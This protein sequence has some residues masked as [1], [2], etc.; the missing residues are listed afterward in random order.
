MK[1]AAYFR[2][3]PL[4]LA[5]L[6]SAFSAP[7]AKAVELP[8][9]DDAAGSE[10]STS[11]P[12]DRCAMLAATAW[13]RTP[14]ARRALLHRFEILRPQCMTHAVFLAALGALWLEEGEPAQ[15]LLWL[16]RS[17]LLNPDQPG[18]QADH[19]LALAALG[20]PAARDALA[21]QWVDREDVPLALR[22]RLAQGAG[23]V[24]KSGN[25]TTELSVSATPANTVDGWIF[26]REA[27]WLFGGESNLDH[28]P[29]L[30]ELTLTPPEGS[31][32]LPVE[33]R[34]RNGGATLADLSW[35]LAYSP[36]A[37]MIVQTG[38][39][40]SARH[41]PSESGT[42]WHHIQWA[43]GVSQQWGQWRGQVLSSLTKVGGPLNEPYRLAR[44]GMSVDREAIGCSLRVA[45]ESELRSHQVTHSADGRTVGGLWNSQCPWPGSTTWNWGLAVRHSVDEP[46]D[47]SRPGGKQRQASLGLR[48]F[49]PLSW[50]VRL[51]ASLRTSLLT[52][53]EGYSPLLENNAI[54]RLNQTQLSIELNRP[55]QLSWLSG[56]EA[57][58]QLQA[59]HQSSNLAI[60]RYQ[61]FSAY[62]GLR[63]RW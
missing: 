50:R 52:D 44:F 35:Q 43:A 10:L 14:V 29:R 15:A 4:G 3:V 34:P 62:G 28:S 26:Y 51:D 55:L 6:V 20:E 1:R 16:E 27:S 46:S 8:L 2:P 48:V 22:Q 49:G 54:R 39:Q 13:P 41:A 21:K 42:D 9:P 30:S 45:V 47:P 5:L 11:L 57:L 12:V 56:A 33:S 53:S 23:T 7:T 38:L 59:V 58:L 40:G 19:A 24:A 63:W 61:G 32:I 17:L 60:F 37:G 31:I 36:R 18:A 25:G